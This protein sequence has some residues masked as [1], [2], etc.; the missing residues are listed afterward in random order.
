[1]DAQAMVHGSAGLLRWRAIQ[2]DQS[3][4]VSARSGDCNHRNDVDDDREH[5]AH[6]HA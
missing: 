3:W 1:M 4:P 2:S 5:D 6:E